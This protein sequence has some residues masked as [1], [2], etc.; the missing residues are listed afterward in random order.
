MTVAQIKAIAV[1]RGYTIS[2]TLKA[3]II[4]EFLTQQEA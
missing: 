3:D 1:E 2:S 4:N